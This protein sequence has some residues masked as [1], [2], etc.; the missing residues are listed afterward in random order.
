MRPP[1]CSTYS[2]GVVSKSTV[3]TSGVAEGGSLD[4][5]IL[6]NSKI[7]DIHVK[8]VTFIVSWTNSLA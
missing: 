5:R 7:V 1:S 2:K 8:F 3:K 6:Q 4:K